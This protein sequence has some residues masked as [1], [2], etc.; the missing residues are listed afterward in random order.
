[1]AE[2]KNFLNDAE[3]SYTVADWETVWLAFNTFIFVDFGDYQDSYWKTDT[4]LL[5]CVLVG[6]YGVCK[7]M[8]T[9]DGIHFFT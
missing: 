7:E 5:A 6:I 8:H 4:P 2:Y 3:L 1:M 9:L